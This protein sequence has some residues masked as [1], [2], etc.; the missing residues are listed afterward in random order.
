M[1]R[2]PLV[3]EV[4]EVSMTQVLAGY[5]NRPDTFCAVFQYGKLCRA[6][7]YDPASLS[8]PVVWIEDAECAHSRTVKENDWNAPRSIHQLAFWPN[9]ICLVRYSRFA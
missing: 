9:G 5:T 8:L 6:R 1:A 2:W 4:L 3:P 7:L